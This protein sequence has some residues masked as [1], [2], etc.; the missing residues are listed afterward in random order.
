LREFKVVD[1]SQSLSKGFPRLRDDEEKDSE[2]F[3]LS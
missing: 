2:H 1:T 3:K